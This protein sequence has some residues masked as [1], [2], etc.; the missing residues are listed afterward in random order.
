[1]KTSVAHA[2]P[3]AAPALVPALATVHAPPDPVHL[4][5]HGAHRIAGDIRRSESRRGALKRAP[6][7]VFDPALSAGAAQGRPHKAMACHAGSAELPQS[8]DNVRK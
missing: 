7:L 2:L 5:F 3:R 6:Q 4:I 8:G 1:M